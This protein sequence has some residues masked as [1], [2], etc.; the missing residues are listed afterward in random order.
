MNIS[1]KFWILI[2]IV[3]SLGQ[4]YNMLVCHRESLFY[5]LVLANRFFDEVSFLISRN[6]ILKIND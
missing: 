3:I 1:T 2:Q 6:L 5:S 4:N